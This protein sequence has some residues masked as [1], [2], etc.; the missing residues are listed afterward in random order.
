MLRFLMIASYISSDR[1]LCFPCARV[2]KLPAA[3]APRSQA[4]R[5]WSLQT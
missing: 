5:S 1:S 3:R 4:R 2:T